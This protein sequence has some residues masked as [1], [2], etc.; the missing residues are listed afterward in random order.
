[1]GP[2]PPSTLPPMLCC[3]ATAGGVG[4]ECLE[5][6]D[7]GALV[8]PRHRPERAAKTTAENALMSKLFSSTVIFFKAPLT[9]FAGATGYSGGVSARHIA[10]GVNGPPRQTEA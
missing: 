7:A 8:C 9:L 2:P 6:I 10:F 5:P 4:A 3:D 1:M